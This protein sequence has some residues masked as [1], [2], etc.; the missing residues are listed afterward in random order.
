[1]SVFAWS[2][3]THILPTQPLAPNGDRYHWSKVN[4]A[5]NTLRD[6]VKE[7]A[8]QHVPP[9][10]PFANYRLHVT[11]SILYGRAAAAAVARESRYEKHLR[12]YRPTDPDDLLA[13]VKS[14]IDGLAVAGVLVEDDFM[15]ARLVSVSIAPCS[16][17][18][19]EGVLFFVRQFDEPPLMYDPRKAQA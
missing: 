16:L 2:M 6:A 7:L 13:A 9:A 17:P 18:D 8:R 11:G 10:V 3:H 15:H 5:R 1:M 14:G 12:P 19:D 4:A